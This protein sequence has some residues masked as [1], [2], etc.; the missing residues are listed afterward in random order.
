VRA[1]QVRQEGHGLMHPFRRPLVGP[2]HRD[3]L[4]GNK[5]KQ[6]MSTDVYRGRFGARSVPGVDGVP[7]RSAGQRRAR[8]EAAAADVEVAASASTGPNMRG[9]LG[10]TVNY[11]GA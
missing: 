7:K 6:K 8:R 10:G 3:V 9:L 1:L 11:W 4:D 2:N 5:V